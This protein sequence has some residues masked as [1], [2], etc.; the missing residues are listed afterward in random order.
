MSCLGIPTINAFKI[1]ETDASEIGYGGILKQ[2]VSPDTSEK[3]VH[4]LSE[5]WNTAKIYYSTIKKKLYVVLGI[6]K[7]QSDLL[8]Q[9]F[10]LCIDF[11][12]DK[13][14]IEKDVE[15]I[16]SKHI[17]A[18][19]QDIL[20][21]L[22]FILILN[23]LKVLKML[24]LNFLPV[25]SFSAT[26]A[27][28]RS[29][30]RHTATDTTKQLVKQEPT[31]PVDIANHFT[32]LGTIPRPNYSIVLASSYDPYATIPTNQPV[33]ATFSK[34]SNASQY[35]KKQYFQNLFSI[36]PNRAII[37]DPLKLATDYFPLNFYWIPEHNGKN[38]NCYSTI[39]FH[40]KSVFIKSITDKIDKSKIIYD[41][42]F[43][44]NAVTEEKQ[45]LHPTSTKPLLG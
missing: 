31:S 27:S 9:K 32:T 18:Q 33:K 35:I 37:R 3:I 41:S 12:S 16:A 14:V 36:E 40:E 7:F 20:S 44:L 11:K 23:I 45:G 24:S 34:N 22:F 25:N 19:W 4:F 5:V 43:I 13:Y 17:F 1:V 28:R 15:N 30:D 39:L 38:L 10:L 21:F 26:M 29:K 6:S 42:V 8:N 2:L